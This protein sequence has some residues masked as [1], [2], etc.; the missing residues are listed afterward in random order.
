M[1]NKLIEQLGRKWEILSI[2][3]N[4]A[5]VTNGISIWLVIEYTSGKVGAERLV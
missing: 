1:S 2:I 5:I 4:T 3:A